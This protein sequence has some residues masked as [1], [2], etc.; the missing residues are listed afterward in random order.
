MAEGLEDVGAWLR[1]HLR[2]VDATCPAET[3]PCMYT[4]TADG[5]FIIDTLAPNVHVGAGFSGHGFKLG[6][7]VGLALADLAEV[8]TCTQFDLA[9]FRADRAGLGL[10]PCGAEPPGDREDAA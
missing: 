5:D 10:G 9:P 6:P 2:G 1:A 7:V 4:W 8:G 3:E